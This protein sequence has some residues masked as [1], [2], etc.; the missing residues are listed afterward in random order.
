MGLERAKCL[1]ILANYANMRRVLAWQN[2]RNL[3]IGEIEHCPGGVLIL[4]SALEGVS[5]PID[6]RGDILHLHGDMVDLV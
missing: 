6:R 5:V 1:R 4:D 3:D 2:K